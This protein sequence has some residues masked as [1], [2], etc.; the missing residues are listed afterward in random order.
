MPATIRRAGKDDARAISE[1]IEEAV[2]EPNPVGFDQPLTP[3]E[4]ETW[5]DRQGESGAMFVLDDGRQVIAFAALDFDSASPEE[6]TLGAWV[7]VR[8]RRQGHATAVAEAALVFAREHG[9]KRIRARLPEQ[10]EAA[11]SFLSSIGGM[12]PIMNPGATY[13]LPLSEDLSE[14]QE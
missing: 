10:N 5:L 3:A 14:D 8:N 12:V 6:C 2:S 4:V 1:I 9:Y 7:R 13:V 11:L